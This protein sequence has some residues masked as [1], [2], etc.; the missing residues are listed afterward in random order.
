MIFIVRFD[1]LFVIFLFFNVDIEVKKFIEG[2]V[3]FKIFGFLKKCEFYYF[4]CVFFYGIEIIIIIVII[5][6]FV[7]IWWENSGW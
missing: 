3:L 7:N 5:Y 4:L 1:I 6:Y 2:V